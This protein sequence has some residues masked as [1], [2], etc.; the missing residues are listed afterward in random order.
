[1]CPITQDLMD[2]PYLCKLDGYSYEKT[3]IV[4][5]LTDSRKSPMTRRMM[6]PDEKIE[7]V[8][9]PNRALKNIIENYKLFRSKNSEVKEAE[10]KAV[11]KNL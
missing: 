11:L 9:I 7:D 2:D 10:S 5:C 1:M 4:Q 3:A 6:A 8:I